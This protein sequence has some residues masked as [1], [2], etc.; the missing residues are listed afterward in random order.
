MAL[1]SGRGGPCHGPKCL[2]MARKCADQGPYKEICKS[3][4]GSGKGR[5]QAGGKE[6]EEEEGGVRRRFHPV[7]QKDVYSWK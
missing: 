4:R 2:P 6:Q 5:G 3:I 1:A 7:E